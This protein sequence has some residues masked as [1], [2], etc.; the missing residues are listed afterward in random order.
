MSNEIEVKEEEIVEKASEKVAE[1]HTEVAIKTAKTIK[2]EKN[3]EIKIPVDPQNPKDL[4][5]PV[6]INGYRWRIKRGEK[7][8]VPASVAKILEEAKYI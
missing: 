4:I 7:V 1:N 6:V 5:V 2:S 8:S 3:V